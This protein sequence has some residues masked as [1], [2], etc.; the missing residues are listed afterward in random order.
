MP[1]SSS[2][3]TWQPSVSQVGSGAQNDA[4][5]HQPQ[6]QHQYQHQHQHQHQ[7]QHVRD[8]T[9]QYSCTVCIVCKLVATA[10]W[11]IMWVIGSCLLF[12]PSHSWHAVRK[13]CRRNMCLLRMLV[14]CIN[15]CITVLWFYC[16]RP[17]CFLALMMRL[18]VPRH[19][20]KL[21]THGET[22][23][24]QNRH[25]VLPRVCIAYFTVIFSAYWWPIF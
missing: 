21:F 23:M 4:A 11:F 6:H 25:S 15:T 3:Y 14:N 10:A 8:C 24:L 1:P 7:P 16:R 18:R 9:C 20:S 2:N 19:S 5:V 17:R 12:C 22:P 13:K